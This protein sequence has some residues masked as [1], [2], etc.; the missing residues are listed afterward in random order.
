[1]DKER[2]ELSQTG[3]GAGQIAL[4]VQWDGLVMLCKLE[5]ERRIKCVTVNREGVR[6]EKF[7]EAGLV[8][9]ETKQKLKRTIEEEWIGHNVEKR[10][11]R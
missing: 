3:S 9:G 7:K 1:M 6:R 10:A 2:R 5:W 11:V 4:V 8:K